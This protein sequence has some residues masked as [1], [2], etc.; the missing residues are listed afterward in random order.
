LEDLKN[1]PELEAFIQSH[2]KLDINEPDLTVRDY[3]PGDPLKKIHWKSTARSGELKVRN[4]IGTLKQRILLLTDTMRGSN[5]KD[6]YLP[7]ENQILEQT[8]ALIYYFIR[9]NIPAD[10]LFL[11]K[12]VEMRNITDI[13]QFNQIYEEF[14]VLAFREDNCFASLYG[15][16]VNSGLLA[17]ATIIFMVIHKLDDELFAGITELSL[18]GRIVIVYVV[19]D[20]DISDYIRQNSDRLKIIEIKL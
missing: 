11:N 3:I 5:N 4:D 18:A 8:I 1:V 9:Q 13:N 12:E 2:L 16:A 7:L 17:Q 6:I 10:V 19:G 14:S 20:D 15:N